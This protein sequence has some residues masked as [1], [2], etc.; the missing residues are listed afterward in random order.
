MKIF[1]I[2]TGAILLQF[3]IPVQLSA[4]T[5][6]NHKNIPASTRI[7]KYDQPASMWTDAMPIGNGR[8]GGMVYGGTHD[9]IVKLN[10]NTVWAGGPRKENTKGGLLYLDSIRALVFEGRG[11]EAEKLFD[12][13]MIPR[14]GGN[15]PYQPLGTLS[16]I[17]PGHSFVEDYKRE[18]L[19]D[20]ALAKVSYR[21]KDVEYERTYFCSYPDQ[22]MAIRLSASKPGSISAY[23][24]IEGLTNPRGTGDEEWGLNHKG[25]SMLI[26]SGKTRSFKSSD[27]R[28]KYESRL[29]VVPEGGK[30]DVIFA[31]NK[32]TIRLTGSN[33]VT[34]YLTAASS[35]I[36]YKDVSGN[37]GKRNDKYLENI[38]NKTY[39]DILTAHIN[40]F[41]NL[42]NKVALDLNGP[43]TE[44]VT[45]PKRFALFAEN[46]DPDFVGLFFQYG[47]YLMISSSRP[48]G[49]PANLQGIWNQDMNPAWGGGYTVNI[50]YEMN[51]WPSDLTNLSECREPQLSTI[52]N[53]AIPG[54]TTAKLNFG[55]DGWN[56]T[57]NTDIWLA[58]D[59]ILPAYW[60]SWQ[61][62]AAWL[63]DDLWD[64]FLFTRDTSYLKEYYPV[65]RDAV[66]FYDQTLVRHPKYGWLVTNPS[67]SPENGPGGDLAWN[68][69]PDGTRNRPIGIAAGPTSDNAMLIDLFEHFITASL[70]LDED[71]EL[72]ESVN[73]KILR[74]PPYQI[75]RYGQLQEWLEDVDNPDDKHRHTSHLWGLYPGTSIDPLKTPKL[76]EAAKVV[77]EHRGDESTGWAMGWRVNLW[78][79]LRDGDRALKLLKRQL[80]LVDS[81]TYGSGPG[82][83]YVNMMDACPPFQIDGNFGGTAGIAEMLLQSQNGYIEFLP[84]LPGKWETG[85]FRGL[86]A[87]GA[88]EVD[89]AWK[90]GKWE[91]ASLLS[92]KGIPC[93][94][95]SDSRIKV[96]CADKLI[97]LNKGKKDLYQFLTDA[98][99]TYRIVAN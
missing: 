6:E 49:V 48:G 97:K 30:M 92:E 26:L 71:K 83:T 17:S 43:N 27:E 85:S 86:K 2:F 29:Q 9:E 79:R 96:Y 70:I 47:R 74:L 60:S 52:K 82:G 24:S 99:K 33:S 19:L 46:K 3:L 91:S 32:P 1:T 44:N 12:K 18:L 55:A 20:S 80:K 87:R 35:F 76:A 15:T 94:I 28:L 98:G 67:S 41:K 38:R 89:L 59:P 65:I 13:T 21:I 8:L 10:E 34:L 50:N 5:I 23:F 39:G 11:K 54:A 31:D 14:N 61:G 95:K 56:F 58:S 90:N 25:D 93:S 69:N 42:F 37:P 4:Q 72:R 45:T 7:L 63:S 81:P 75:G 53:M 77:L 51:Y 36:S 62:A 68:Y 64:H 16:I 84:A 40:D 73:K 22:V 88:F 78:A 66:R 57:L